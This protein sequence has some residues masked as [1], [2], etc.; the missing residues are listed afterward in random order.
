MWKIRKISSQKT[1]YDKLAILTRK[2]SSDRLEIL[3]DR[4]GHPPPP[5]P[6]IS[7]ARS[8]LVSD[9]ESELS[10]ISYLLS[11]SKMHFLE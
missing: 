4:L 9:L 6:Y 2:E 8:N 7:M 5:P 1:L 3:D 11:N 10:R